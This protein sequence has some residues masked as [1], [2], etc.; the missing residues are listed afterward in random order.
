[1]SFNARVSYTAN[2]STNTFSFSFPYI[3]TSHVKAFVNGVEDTNITFPTSSSVQL[4][5]TPANGAVVLIQRITPSDARLVDFQDGSVLTS[6]DLDR[7]ADQNFFI[8]QETSD[9]VASK[10]GLDASDRFDANNK[11]I[12]NVANP[13]DAQDAVT[14]HYL[15]NTWLSPTDKSNINTVAGISGIATLASNNAN[16]NT[17]ATN[18]ANVNAVGNDIAKVIETANDLQEAV[19]EID[20]VATNI[21]NVNLVGADIANVNTVAT[22]VSAVNAFGSTY[23]ISANAPTGIPEGTLWFDTTND[24]MKV[25]DGNAFQ[26][27]GSSVNGTSQ[28]NKFIATANQTTF[29]GSDADGVTLAYDPNFLDV[30]LNGIRLVNST[31]YT[32]TNGSSIVLSSGASVGDILNI[33]SFGTFNIASFSATAITSDTLPI[34]RGGTGLNSVSG[35]AGK[36]LIVNS[37]ANGFEL[38]NASSAEVYGFIKSF[39]ASTIEYTVTVQSVG[40]SNKYFIN[41]EQQP[42]LELLEGNTYV[43]NYPSAHPFKFSTTSNG[44]HGGGSEYTTGV[45][46]NSS[47]QVTIVVASGAPT[48]YYYCSSH[49]GMGGQANTPVPA[50][51]TLQ[52]ITTNQGQDNITNAQYNS[53]TDTLFS[54]SGFTFSLNSSGSLIATI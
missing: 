52:V 30:Y 28:R 54:A 47:T 10:L 45:T 8:S 29:S 34:A 12:I 44:S 40:G 14:K 3:L 36:A 15:E 17:V 7:S 31:D 25:Y 9:D 22:N 20:V 49:S 27:A 11:R 42:T 21:A 39:T 4:S 43:F 16:I 33:V 5:S 51:N 18:I 19:S 26:N 38:A 1:M 35:Q 24:V 50:N 32:A 53:F 6:S 2:G 46:H 41:G 23:K 13:T 37:N 48:L